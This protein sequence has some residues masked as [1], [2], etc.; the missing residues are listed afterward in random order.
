MYSKSA[1]PN[2]NIESRIIITNKHKSTKQTKE[3]AAALKTQSYKPKSSTLS[4][5]WLQFIV[6]ISSTRIAKYW[7]RIKNSKTFFDLNRRIVVRFMD[8]NRFQSSMQIALNQDSWLNWHA[9]KWLACGTFEFQMILELWQ[10]HTV[11][12]K[13]SDTLVT[14]AWPL[15]CLIDF[16]SWYV[17]DGWWFVWS[18]LCSSRLCVL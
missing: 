15:C 18:D 7:N 14:W 11:S 13:A 12:A 8:S 5:L 9:S 6:S 3:R 17:G 1:S 16:V 4:C 2:S 10:K